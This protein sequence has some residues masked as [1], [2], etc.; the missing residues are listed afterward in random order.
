MIRPKDRA[1]AQGLLPLMEARPW[2]DGKTVTYRYHPLRGKPINLGTDRE[3]AIR[4]VLDLTRSGPA[5]G[6]IAG[7]WDTYQLTPLW[8]DLKPR[9]QQ[10]YT[11]YSV[12]VL[13]V[14]GAMQAA[15]IT[16]PMI[17]Q[18]LRVE[19]SDAP[20]RANREISLLSILIGLA[21]E[22]GEAL[23]NP[24]RERQVKRN[25]ERPRTVSPETADLKALA[26]FAQ[27]RGGQSLIICGA[28][29]FAAL[30]GS[31]QAEF[32]D[33]TWT[34]VT[35]TE[36]RLKRSKQRGRDERVERIEISPAMRELLGRM[37]A[38]ATNP[39]EGTVFRNQ[40]GNAYTYFGFAAQWQKFI[41]AALDAKVIRR[42]FTFHDLRAHYVTA[43]KEQLGTLPEIHASP[44]TT[45]KVYDRSAASR[46][47]AL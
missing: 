9:T 25:K 18:Y 17:A 11:A 40:H 3:A 14:F 33:M 21:I 30:A 27:A 37:R 41:K 6:T 36:V 16:A 15:D 24:C 38:L 23:V 39:R 32:L 29:E 26:A 7:L 35:S 4:K 31:R 19:R 2:K 22:R 42:K 34:Q 46:R 10:D 12:A 45:A 13:R 28:A 43:H 47:K 20:V 1:S 8:R 5:I 44:T